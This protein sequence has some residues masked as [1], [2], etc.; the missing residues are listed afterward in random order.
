MPTES[1]SLPRMYGMGIAGTLCS[2]PMKWTRQAMAA[3]EGGRQGGQPHSQ[4]G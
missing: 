4:E 3:S 2:S 1:M